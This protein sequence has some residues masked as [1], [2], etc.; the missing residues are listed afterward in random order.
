M[1]HLWNEVAVFEKKF[2]GW[3]QKWS[4]FFFNTENF[5]FSAWNCIQLVK[6]KFVLMFLNGV[7][8]V[9]LIM[10]RK[11]RG[12]L[13]ILIKKNLEFVQL[14]KNLG[15][16]QNR[17]NICWFGY[18]VTYIRI[19]IIQLIVDIVPLKFNWQTVNTD[20]TKDRLAAPLSIS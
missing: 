4:K 17:L 7:S 5:F 12:N 19:N 16:P 1:D 9:S 2:K 18:L 15:S 13:P 10:L 3:K 8:C 20:T 14:L 6:K 11:D